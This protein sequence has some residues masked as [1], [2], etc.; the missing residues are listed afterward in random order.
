M[1]DP[2]QAPAAGQ[3]AAPA[4]TAVCIAPQGDGSFVVYPKDAGPEA[5]QTAPGIDSALE[6]VK[7]TLAGATAQGTAPAAAEGATSADSLFEQGFNNVRGVPLNRA[8]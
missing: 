3:S 7:Q 1:I 5:G 8:G 2:T 4:Q 6:L